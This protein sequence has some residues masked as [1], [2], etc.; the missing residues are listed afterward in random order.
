[1]SFNDAHE[2]VMNGLPRFFP[3][4]FNVHAI[5]FH[6][7]SAQTIGVFMQLLQ[8]AS[9]WTY[10]AMTKDIITVASNTHYLLIW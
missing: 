4:H 8:R 5:L 9:L 10:K 1:M 2:T 6:Q 7:W 3:T